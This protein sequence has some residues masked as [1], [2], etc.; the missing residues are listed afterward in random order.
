MSTSWRIVV[1]PL[2]MVTILAL[3]SGLGCPFGTC[4]NPSGLSDDSGRPGDV[5]T[6]EGNVNTSHFTDVEFNGEVVFSNTG[7]PSF[8]VP[9]LPPGQYTVTIIDSNCGGTVGTFEFTIREP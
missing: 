9:S 5:V 3:V 6:V 4:S 7:R 2:A 1:L 8:T